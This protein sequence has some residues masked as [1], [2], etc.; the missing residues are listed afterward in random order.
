MIMNNENKKLSRKR[1]RGIKGKRKI[2]DNMKLILNK[3]KTEKKKKKKNLE[4]IE[5]L[6]IL[7]VRIKY[8]N[9][10]NKITTCFERV[11]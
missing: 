11:K 4:K 1:K 2:D 9:Y 5:Q 3:I 6:E 10:P 7:L 8:A